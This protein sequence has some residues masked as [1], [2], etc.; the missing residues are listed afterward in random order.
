MRFSLVTLLLA[1]STTLVSA[2][3]F[4]S[5][6]VSGRDLSA[7]SRRISRRSDVE[8]LIAVRDLID[9]LLEEQPLPTVA[10][11][12]AAAAE[13]QKWSLAEASLKKAVENIKT[14]PVSKKMEMDIRKCLRS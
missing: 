3:D 13:L 11:Q 10:D 14:N 6:D 2:Y 4:D 8:D 1:A 5:A 12:K 9:T 7:R